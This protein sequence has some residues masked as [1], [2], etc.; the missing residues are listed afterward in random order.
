MNRSLELLA[1]DELTP[2]EKLFNKLGLVKGLKYL[3]QK[4]MGDDTRGTTL[5][6]TVDKLNTMIDAEEVN[7]PEFAKL[8]GNFVDAAKGYKGD[9]DGDGIMSGEGEASTARSGVTG[10]PA[11][12]GGVSVGEAGRGGG[13]DRGGDAGG[14]SG[15][16]GFS[17]DYGGAGSGSPDFMNKGGLAGKKP[18]KKA[19]RKMKKG[20]L[21]TSKK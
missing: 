9:T 6:R 7:T 16:A 2:M 5:G 14:F 15:N 13:P 20:G 8:A 10:G 12:V 3:D 11:G 4:I 1:G 17:G 18:K 21:A 19:T